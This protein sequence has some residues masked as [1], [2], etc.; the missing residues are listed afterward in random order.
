MIIELGASPAPQALFGGAVFWQAPFLWAASATVLIETPLF[1]L[2]GYRR[3]RD[4]LCF[5][6]INVVSNLLLNESLSE[7]WCYGE[8]LFASGLVLGELLVL[9]LEF[10]L[11]RLV[12]RGGSRR[13]FGVLFV[14]NLTSL[15]CGL[16]FQ[17]VM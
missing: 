14:T 13:L 2:L 8:E 1:C 4:W 3:L 5:A 15:L 6:G 10:A 17:A 16:C 11:C 9:L 12:V 7:L